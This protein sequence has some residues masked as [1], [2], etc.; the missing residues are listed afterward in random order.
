MGCNS[1]RRRPGSSGLDAARGSRAGD[2]RSAQPDSP[3]PRVS[4]AAPAQ[5]RRLPGAGGR[6]PPGRLLGVQATAGLQARAPG[7]SRA[8]GAPA[9]RPRPARPAPSRPSFSNQLARQTPFP[10]H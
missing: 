4:P 9:P 6:G 8:G 1:G 5:P 3:A 7:A 2:Q 10:L